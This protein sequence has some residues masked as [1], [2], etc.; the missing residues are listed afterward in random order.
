MSSSRRSTLVSLRYKGNAHAGLWF[1]KYLYSQEDTDKEPYASER[2]EKKTP[3]TLHIQR[4]AQIASATITSPVYRSFFERWQHTLQQRNVV[5]GEATVQGRMVVG[6]GAES[7]LETAIALHRTYGVPYIPGSALKGLAAS[8]ARQ[9]LGWKTDC[10]PYSTLFGSIVATNANGKQTGEA[11][12]VTFFDA[13]PIPGKAALH[14]DVMAVHHP[15]Y[16]QNDPP[17]APADWDS[18]TIIP[19]LSATG[20]Y[21]TALEGEAVWVELSCDLLHH[22]LKHMGIGAKTSSGYGR[23]KLPISGRIG[24]TVTGEV[25]VDQT[26][27]VDDAPENMIGM[28]KNAEHLIGQQITAL[29]VNRRLHNDQILL[30]LAPLEKEH[31]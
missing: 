3:A 30:A 20:S 29:V 10:P 11:G 15:K 22:A 7:V 21:L 4:T 23:M 24:S 8:F 26:V 25:Q 6:L 17:A 13:L 31:T 1:D 27:T 18:P 5:P 12:G 14:A 2:D 16:Y 19:F 28:L 9:R